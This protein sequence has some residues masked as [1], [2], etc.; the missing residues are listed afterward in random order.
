MKTDCI[1][2]SLSMDLSLCTNFPKLDDSFTA[3]FCYVRAIEENGW[4]HSV[5][6]FT[7]TARMG[8]LSWVEMITA[9]LWTCAGCV[10]STSWRACLLVWLLHLYGSSWS[11]VYLV[12]CRPTALTN[13]WLAGWVSFCWF[14]LFP[15]KRCRVGFYFIRTSYLMILFLYYGRAPAYFLVFCKFQF[16][17]SSYWMTLVL[18]K[19]STSYFSDC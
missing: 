14:P 9:S 2:A 18:V 8:V 7:F 12:S 4:C 16:K 3:L 19:A 1:A 15:K 11:C 17:I 6:T 10:A 5:E 13:Q